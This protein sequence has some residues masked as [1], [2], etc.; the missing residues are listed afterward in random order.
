MRRLVPALLVAF[1]LCQI[2]GWARADHGA[3]GC[4]YMPSNMVGFNCTYW[5]YAMIDLKHQALTAAVRGDHTRWW[6][7]Q[8]AMLQLE[9]D[10]DRSVENGG[11]GLSIR[12]RDSLEHFQAHAFTAV[13]DNVSYATV[14]QSMQNPDIGFMPRVIIYDKL[15]R[16]WKFAGSHCTTEFGWWVNTVLTFTVGFM[17]GGRITQ[18]VGAKWGVDVVRVVGSGEVAGGVFSVATG[19]VIGLPDADSCEALVDILHTFPDGRQGVYRN[20]VIFGRDGGISV[21]SWSGD[22]LW[23]FMGYVGYDEKGQPVW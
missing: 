4:V 19:L 15:N 13:G 10:A 7:L 20:R 11:D 18:A 12:Y 3:T 1:L 23:K 21:Q 5:D 14:P 2:P 16:P 17:P 22:Q 8:S 6:Q 9:R